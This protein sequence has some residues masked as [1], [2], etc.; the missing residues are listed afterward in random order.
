MQEL[1]WQPKYPYL[2]EIITHAWQW[3]KNHPNGYGD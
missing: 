2:K 3:H 1:G